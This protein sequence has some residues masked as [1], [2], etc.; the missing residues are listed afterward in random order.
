M[1]DV[2][3]IKKL[4][5]VLSYLASEYEQ[6]H[7]IDIILEKVDYIANVAEAI[8]YTSKIRKRRVYHV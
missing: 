1:L 8:F 7:N 2:T 3:P 6:R 5:N 4:D